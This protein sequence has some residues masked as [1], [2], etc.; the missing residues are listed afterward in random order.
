MGDQF[1][2][3]AVIQAIENLVREGKRAY[4]HNVPDV[5]NAILLAQEGAKTTRADARDRVR[6]AI[7]ASQSE[8]EIEC[9]AEPRK[10]WKIL[11]ESR[12]DS[13][14]ADQDAKVVVL[15]AMD[16]LVRAG[17]RAYVHNVPEEATK[18]LLRRE[19]GRIT[20][21]DANERVKRAIESLALE[22]KIDCHLEPYK[23]W[24][25]LS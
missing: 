14:E 11:E 25:I 17:Q 6:Q 9:H 10:D 18:F 23:D 24:K 19:A 13:G 20:R 8:G 4:S 2:K 7:V 5:A 3:D 16:G 12:H 1:A 21:S 22:G 15:E